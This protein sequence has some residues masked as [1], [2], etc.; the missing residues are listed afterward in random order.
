[1][2]AWVN[3]ALRLKADHD[4]RL[5]AAPG[6]VRSSCA[7]TRKNAARARVAAGARPDAGAGCRGVRGGGTREP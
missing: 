3:D 5:A 1:V 4:R 2:S 7:V 6:A